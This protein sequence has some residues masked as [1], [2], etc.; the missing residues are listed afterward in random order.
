VIRPRG[1]PLRP[2]GVLGW[3]AVGGVAMLQL[4]MSALWWSSFGLYVVAFTTAFAWSKTALS[5]GYALVQLQGGI[6]GPVLGAL[7]DR[8]GARRVVAAGVVLLGVGIF[9]MGRIETLAGFYGA[10]LLVG[11]GAAAAGWVPMTAALIPWFVRYRAR[12]MA[13]SAA[14]AS[15]GGL[16]VPLVA[17]AIESIGWRETL[18]LSGLLTIA[19]GLPVAGLLRRDPERYGQRPDGHT[20]ARP[21]REGAPVPAAP[22]EGPQFTLRE[23]MRTSP[24][25]LLGVG[26]G[27]A[28][29]VVSAVSVHLVAH[30]TL[31]RGFGL[32]GA[33]AMVAVLTIVSLIG[34]LAGG[35]FGDR[36]EKRFVAAW[37]MMGHA[38]ALLVLAWGP[39]TASVVLAVSLHGLAWG[40]RGP[41]MGAI[42]ADY[43]G[44]RHF[45]VI[46]GASMLLA[47]VGQ[48]LGPIIA[49]TLAD[50]LGDYRMGFTVLAVL[51][52]ASS[53]AF[54]A[55][56]AP[57]RVDGA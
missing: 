27:A 37:G 46:L 14:G 49:G 26:H 52:A 18:Q 10:M 36:F 44:A 34:Q 25:W 48:L 3:W 13:L 23:A 11:L 17:A 56:R 47:M 29:L 42:R 53:A 20:A 55:A 33:A 45:G 39:G 31:D 57:Q 35:V 7:V 4:I 9:L 51:A 6:T 30:L 1:L 40:L 38:A 5:T 24:F 15:V 41:L 50:I 28:L 32:A 43:F 16:L 21:E 8:V 19:I 22:L 2:G 12:A 54:A